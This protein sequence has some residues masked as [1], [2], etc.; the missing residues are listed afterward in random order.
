MVLKSSQGALRKESVT[1]I[2]SIEPATVANA[3]PFPLHLRVKGALRKG[4]IPLLFRESYR[5]WSHFVGVFY[6]PIFPEV[7]FRGD[8]LH[9]V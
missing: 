8:C 5:V 3:A 1:V 7:D 9:E 2:A 6:L 4:R